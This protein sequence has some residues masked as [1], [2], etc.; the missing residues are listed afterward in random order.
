MC[1][2]WPQTVDTLVSCLGLYV[3]LIGLRASTENTLRL[4]RHYMLGLFAAGGAWILFNFFF[5]AA[6]ER[7][8]EEQQ[9]EE[10]G[11]DK[12]FVP[13]SDSDIYSQALQV[14]VLPGM[15]WFMCWVRAWHFHHLLHE[16]EREATERMQSQAGDDDEN[17]VNHDEELA[18]SNNQAVLA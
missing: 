1:R 11:N 2:G 6:V 3:A 15:V 10:H 7:K 18:L 16:A 17:N 14:M 13:M 4:A 12:D 9:E 8:V 5:M